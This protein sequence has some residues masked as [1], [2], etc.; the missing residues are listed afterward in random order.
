MA[1]PN[2]GGTKTRIVGSGFKPPRSTV[3]TKWGVLSTDIIPKSLVEDY[4]YYKLQFENMIE[5]S[6]E[7][8]AYIY[9]AAQFP[10]VDTL[11]EETNTYHA[12]YLNPP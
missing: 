9:E 2:Q 1:G 3:Q 12:V 5:G 10:R 6:E 8:K 11:L 4:V 7:L